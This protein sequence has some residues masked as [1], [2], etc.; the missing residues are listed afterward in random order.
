MDKKPKIKLTKEQ[1]TEMGLEL[2]QSYVESGA[3]I[4]TDKEGAEHLK[5]MEFVDA[6]K[7]QLTNAKE[8]NDRHPVKK[9]HKKYPTNIQR[10]K[11]KR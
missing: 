4:V 3:T 1:M 9:P 6:A 5:H 11:K 7:K 2:L 8:F 10:P